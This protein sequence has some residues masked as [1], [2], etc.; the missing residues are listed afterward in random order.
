[1]TTSLIGIIGKR[2]VSDFSLEVS[3]FLRQAAIAP[4]K[5]DAGGN[6]VDKP[7]HPACRTELTGLF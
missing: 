6:A 2:F 7:T 3:M 1:M 4:L 5:L